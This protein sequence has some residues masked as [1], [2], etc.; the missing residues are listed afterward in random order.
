M[1]PQISPS[2][3]TNNRFQFNDQ[4]SGPNRG[5]YTPRSANPTYGKSFRGNYQRNFSQTG[6]G[7]AGGGGGNSTPRSNWGNNNG[8][9]LFVKANN[10]TEELL[11]SLISSNVSEAKI[12]SIDVKTKYNIET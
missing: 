2:Y 1:S 3:N 11:R 10:V 6:P 7:G 9:A 12:I 4:Q 8:V 5:G